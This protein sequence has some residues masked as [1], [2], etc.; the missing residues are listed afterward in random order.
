MKNSLSWYALAATLY[1]CAIV[2]AIT[3]MARGD[4]GWGGATFFLLNTICVLLFE[5]RNGRSA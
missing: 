5:R 2:I 1:C 3:T 4:I